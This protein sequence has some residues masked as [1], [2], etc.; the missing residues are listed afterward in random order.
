MTSQVVFA[1]PV[2]TPIGTFAGSLKDVPAT[3]LGSAAIAAR[4]RPRKSS[5][6]RTS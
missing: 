1:E 6:I 3:A 5:Q 2:R 4:G